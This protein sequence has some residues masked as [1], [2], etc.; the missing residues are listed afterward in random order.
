VSPRQANHG[1]APLRRTSEIRK[2][3][4]PGALQY[5]ADARNQRKARDQAGP[6]IPDKRYAGEVAQHRKLR[7]DRVPRSIRPLL[8]PSRAQPALQRST[9]SSEHE[10]KYTGADVVDR[11]LGTTLLSCVDML[12]GAV[13]RCSDGALLCE[14]SLIM[15]L[16]SQNTV[17]ACSA[18]V[19][20][21]Y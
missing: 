3:R 13:E 12:F 9:E 17:L 16:N 8:Q 21:R 15:L 20:R 6:E 11:S 14:R 5:R 1:P 18:A 10:K 19:T 4:P 2:P 7:Q